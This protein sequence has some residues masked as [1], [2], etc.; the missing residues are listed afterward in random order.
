MLAPCCE[1][2]GLSLAIRP[3]ISIKTATLADLLRQASQAPVRPLDN[4]VGV[5]GLSEPCWSVSFELKLRRDLQD[6]Q[7]RSRNGTTGGKPLF[8]SVFPPL[9]SW[10]RMRLM[11]QP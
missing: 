8:L 2:S 11:P 1:V 3:C 10:E 6:A 5:D 9:G 7:Q 4:L